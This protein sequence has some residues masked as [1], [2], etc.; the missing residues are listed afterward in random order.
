MNLKRHNS[1][2]VAIINFY[3]NLISTNISDE[4]T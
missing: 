3:S 4:I 1:G 2:F